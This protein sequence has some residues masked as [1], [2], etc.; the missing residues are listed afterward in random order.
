MYDDEIK[1]ANGAV[2]SFKDDFTRIIFEGEIY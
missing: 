1:A 2:A